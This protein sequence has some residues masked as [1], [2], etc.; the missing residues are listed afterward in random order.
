MTNNRYDL[1]INKGATFSKEIRYKDENEALINLTGYTA[2]MHIRETIDSST[3]IVTLTT[4]NGGITL[5]GVAGTII[6][7]ISAAD[8]AAIT[9]NTGV[10]DLEIISG[11]GLVT[12]LLEGEVQF[13]D[14]VTR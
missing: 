9:Q 8:T 3:T 5:G 12:R 11:G 1:I 4:E 7:T 6:L 13:T 10:Y 14:N 2:R